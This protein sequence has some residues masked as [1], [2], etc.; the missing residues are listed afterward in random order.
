[1]SLI[2][3]T[4]LAAIQSLAE[5]G[6]TSSA[7]ILTRAT[8]E[9]D[10]GQESVWATSATNVPCWV[11]HAT[12][13]SATLGALAGGVEIA[14]TFAIRFAV[15]TEVYPADHIVVGSVTYVVESTNISA[16]VAP[17]LVCGCRTLD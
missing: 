11:H 8:V 17:W 1:M 13:T 10:D 15:G 7:T 16:T 9:T 4:E 3:A 12:P 5:S 2:S 14:Q 6:M